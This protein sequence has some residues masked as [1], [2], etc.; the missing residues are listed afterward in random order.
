MALVTAG[1]TQ[2]ISICYLPQVVLTIGMMLLLLLV[3]TIAIYKV[4]NAKG[5]K[6]VQILGHIYTFQSLW[7][8]KQEL[9]EK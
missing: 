6:V 3:V 9:L 4:T 5:W 8:W 2:V 7:K 1:N